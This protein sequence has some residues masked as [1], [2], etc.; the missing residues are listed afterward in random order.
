MTST[1]FKAAQ[2]CATAA[3]LRYLPEREDM[4]W[5]ADVVDRPR[6]GWDWPA[7]EQGFFQPLRD[8][9]DLH[10]ARLKPA[11]AGLLIDAL[12]GDKSEHPAL[13]AALEFTHLASFMLDDLANGRDLDASASDKVSVPLPVWVTIAY[14]AR[15]LAPVLVLRRAENLEP[16]RR[17]RLARRYL[18]QQSLGTAMDLWG[19]ERGLEHGS[20]TDFIVHLSHYAGAPGL[21]LAAATAAE[22]AKLDGEAVEALRKA[23]MELGV[24]LRL[25]AMADGEPRALRLDG[26][27]VAEAEIR[28]RQEYDR[29]ALLASADRLQA[30]AQDAAERL[31]PAIGRAMNDFLAALGAPSAAEAQR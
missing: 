16:A 17:L 2:Q 18:F 7:L 4:D 21:G 22:A 9:A 11:L 13:L 27:Q 26:R 25:R 3:L 19:A 12:G 20:L 28:W 30:S 15:Q 24:S 10:D 5:L 29:G 23:G 14:N 8:W 6:F 31:D 1:R